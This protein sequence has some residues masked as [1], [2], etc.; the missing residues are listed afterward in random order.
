MVK[1]RRFMSA[2]TDADGRHMAL[3]R[4]FVQIKDGKAMGA[5]LP[6]QIHLADR[7]IRRQ[8]PGPNARIERNPAAHPF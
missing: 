4:L 8:P 5:E 6:G 7:P 3:D 2:S 1:R